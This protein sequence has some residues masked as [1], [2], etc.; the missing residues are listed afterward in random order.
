MNCT[1][2]VFCPTF[3]VHSFFGGAFFLSLFDRRVIHQAYLFSNHD[4]D[5]DACGDCVQ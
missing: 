3:G 2:K 1:P 4:R 5:N